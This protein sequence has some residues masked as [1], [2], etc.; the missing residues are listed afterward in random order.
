IRFCLSLLAIF[1][2]SAF[3]MF[4]V[5]ADHNAPFRNRGAT[6]FK[7]GQTAGVP[8][9][10]SN[11]RSQH[12]SRYHRCSFKTT[13]CRSSTYKRPHMVTTYLDSLGPNKEVL[14]RS[15]RQH[16]RN[17]TLPDPKKPLLVRL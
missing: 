1:S 5:V 14:L 8:I 12:S 4:R 7:A 15:E 11:N 3:R 13:D 9:S 6:S 16:A 10:I 17:K 2:H